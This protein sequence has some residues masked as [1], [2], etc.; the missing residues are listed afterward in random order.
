[1]GYLNIVFS[2]LQANELHVKLEK[3]Q[4]GQREVKYLGH[5]ITTEGVSV[6]LE[7]IETMFTWPKPQTPKALRGFLGLTGYYCKFIQ[8]YGKIA[9]P[10]TRMLKKDSFKW[11][12]VSLEAF[13][14]LKEALTGA[15]VLALPDFSKTF[16][17]E[18]DASGSGVGAVLMQDRP[19][20]FFSQALQDSKDHNHG[21]TEVVIQVDGIRFRGGVQKWEGK[22]SCKC[23]LQEI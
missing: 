1:M 9:G 11:N 14:R 5:L 19:I 6:D 2:I 12:E 3:R 20:A 18:F 13:S 23:S 17:V 7:K 8:N 10:L 16:I 22:Y 4:F 21:S 15:P